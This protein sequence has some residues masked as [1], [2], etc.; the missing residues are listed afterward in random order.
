MNFGFHHITK[1]LLLWRHL[2]LF[3]KPLHKAYSWLWSHP[4]MSVALT[5][6]PSRLPSAVLAQRFVGHAVGCGCSPA[7]TSTGQGSCCWRSR[8]SP[9]G[10]VCC[11]H[12]VARCLLCW[13]S[14]AGSLATQWTRLENWLGR[15][16]TNF[17][18]FIFLPASLVSSQ[19]SF[20]ICFTLGLHTCLCQAEEEER[21]RNEQAGKSWCAS[22]RWQG[23]ATLTWSVLDTTAWFDHKS[24]EE[25]VKGALITW[26]ISVMLFTE[27]FTARTAVLT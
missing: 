11:S 15:K 13:Q 19:I 27:G 3:G 26:I 7:N 25:K 8:P 5:P 24:L 17:D 1:P 23:W 20:L 22:S 4:K 21:H 14:T 9:L 2:V 12:P 6:K 16:W 10:Q 18:W